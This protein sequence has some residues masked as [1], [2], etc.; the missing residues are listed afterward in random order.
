MTIVKLLKE[1]RDW[2]ETEVCQGFEFKRAPAVDIQ[3]CDD[4]KYELVK[5][6]AFLMYPPLNEKFPSVTVQF[7]NGR[8]DVNKESGEL[9]LRFLFATWNPGTHYLNKE[10]KQQL[11]ITHQG[12]QDVWNFIDFALQKLKNTDYIGPHIRIKQENGIEFG[13]MTEQD[14]MANYY[15][16]WC[17][18]ITFTIQYGIA[19]VKDYSNLI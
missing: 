4:Y 13:P 18:W 19:T 5:P 10:K 9:K 6:N 14:T 17:G 1:V 8:Q 16:H 12:W 11:E 7:G 3:D 15:P 2:L